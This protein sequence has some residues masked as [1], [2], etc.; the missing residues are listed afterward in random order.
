M[1]LVI[2]KPD[3]RKQ[4]QCADP[5]RVLQLPECFGFDLSDTL[6]GNGKTLAYFF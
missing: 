5:Y 1:P 3:I 6:S 4:L 2:S